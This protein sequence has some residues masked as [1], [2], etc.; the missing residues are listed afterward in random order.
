MKND[1]SLND[2]YNMMRKI[3][4]VFFLSLPV[5]LFYT[6]KTVYGQPAPKNL[7]KTI[8]VDAGHGGEDNGARGDFSFE[9]D[10]CLDIALKVG[11]LLE[12]E[13]PDTKILYTRV[14]DVY[15]TIHARADFANANKIRGAN[16][17]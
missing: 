1:Q 14:T 11:K 3:A 15:P 13:L 6:R 8:I 10:I 17:H 16:F 9:K 2:L 5:I 12:E 4:F 7:L